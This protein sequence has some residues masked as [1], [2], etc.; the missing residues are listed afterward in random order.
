[1]AGTVS[2]WTV[3][4]TAVG[5]VLLW[6]GLKGTSISAT[7]RSILA[8]QAPSGDTETIGTPTVSE[9]SPTSSASTST[10]VTGTSESDWIDSLLSGIG[11]PDTAANVTSIENW[12]SAEGDF[13]AAS[14]NNPLNTT[15][16][17]PGSSG[18]FNS[19]GVQNYATEAD[20]LAATIETLESGA[21]GDILLLLRGGRGLSSGASTGL[22]KWSG[23]A[24][25]SV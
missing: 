7:V 18:G 4:Y 10:T 3:G 20:G 16:V 11:A 14:H 23:G 25:S 12:I 2:G 17:T 5:G 19:T 15:L 9:T 8:G 22:L 1:M 13:S 6:S 21:Y 24:Y